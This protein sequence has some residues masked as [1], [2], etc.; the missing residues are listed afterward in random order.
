MSSPFSNDISQD[1]CDPCPGGAA[2]VP[3]SGCP[4]PS[5]LVPAC[6]TTTP[7]QPRAQPVPTTRPSAPP[8]TLSAIL[9]GKQTA[10][11]SAPRAVASTSSI[12]A[13]MVTALPR[14]RRIVERTLRF[15]VKLPFGNQDAVRTNAIRHDVKKESLVKTLG[16]E[17]QGKPLDITRSMLTALTVTARND[18][19][20][21][22]AVNFPGLVEA[23]AHHIGSSFVHSGA[24]LLHPGEVKTSELIVDDALVEDQTVTSLETF[25]KEQLETC[26][27][28]SSRGDW[29][30]FA[31]MVLRDPRTGEETAQIN[32]VLYNMFENGKLGNETDELWQSILG[33]TKKTE[34][35]VDRV[36]YNR[37]KQGLIDHATNMRTHLT[38]LS[39]FSCVV[40]RADG[41]NFAEV[42]EEIAEMT[43]PLGMAKVEEFV[44][45]PARVRIDAVVEYASDA[46][47]HSADK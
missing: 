6:P 38:D 25:S 28:S 20:F 10:S 45:T 22:V 13:K 40:E 7:G 21:P 3:S 41:M 37:Y 34:V 43:G 15:T 11:P 35:Q 5:C 46:F 19:M 26:E 42:P 8:A 16:G 33:A 18:S 47:M 27:E 39:N 4:P 2:G 32:P 9:K 23:E 29:R 17:F 44:S 30:C 14:Q 24:I 12:G 1:P 31:L 36:P